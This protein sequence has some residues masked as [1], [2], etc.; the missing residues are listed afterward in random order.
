MAKL[1][2]VLRDTERAIYICSRQWAGGAGMLT[3]E[4]R[5]RHVEVSWEEEEKTGRPGPHGSRR[6]CKS[7][8]K[9]VESKHVPCMHVCTLAT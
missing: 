7:R 4:A 9:G 5:W 6:G 1:V 3:N 2:K 8:V